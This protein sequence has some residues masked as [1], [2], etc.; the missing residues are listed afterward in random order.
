[1]NV[2]DGG[3]AAKHRDGVQAVQ[4]EQVDILL[5]GGHTAQL[6][7]LQE[8]LRETRARPVYIGEIRAFDHGEAPWTSFSSE[9]PSMGEGAGES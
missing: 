3:I 9:T 1:M 4:R 8:R 5:Q 6:R 2:P 7:L